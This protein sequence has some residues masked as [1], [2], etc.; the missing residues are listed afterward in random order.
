MTASLEMDQ[1]KFKEKIQEKIWKFK[2][3]IQGKF[4]IGSLLEPNQPFL[5]FL[6]K[7]VKFPWVL[8]IKY[9]KHMKEI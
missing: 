8:L 2:E 4:W 1:R 9:L 3:I 5:H 7:K 6:F